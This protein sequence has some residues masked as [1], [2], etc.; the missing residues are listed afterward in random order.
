MSTLYNINLSRDTSYSEKFLFYSDKCRSTLMDLTGYTF[1]AEAKVAY[2]DVDPAFEFTINTSELADGAVTFILSNV[3]TEVITAGNY[4]WDLR[5]IDPED[6]VD[7]WIHGS[8][9]VSD[10]VTR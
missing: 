9:E 8:V 2:D 7:R 4:I 1:K 5:V 3:E 6:V 10:T